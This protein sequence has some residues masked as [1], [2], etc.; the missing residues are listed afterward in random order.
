MITNTV[1]R[2]AAARGES[3]PDIPLGDRGGALQDIMDAHVSIAVTGLRGKTST[4]AMLAHILSVLGNDP[5]WLLGA[6][7]VGYGAG[8]RARRGAGAPLVLEA[9]PSTLATMTPDICVISGGRQGRPCPRIGRFAT[10]IAAHEEKARLEALPDGAGPGNLVTYGPGPGATWTM[11]SRPCGSG[12]RIVARGPDGEVLWADVPVPVH[13][14]NAMGALVAATALGIAPMDAARALE[15][16]QGVHRHLTIA[17][18]TRSVTVL[19]SVA[20]RPDSIGADLAAARELAG[21]NGRVRVLAVADGLLAHMIRISALL[22]DVD[23]VLT[24]EPVR[25]SPGDQGVG[26][27]R[28][29]AAAA[30]EEITERARPGDVIVILG[31]EPPVERLAGLVLD[32]LGDHPPI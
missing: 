4:A 30:V 18:A 24:L 22:Q 21:G 29:D 25:P 32:A 3:G 6:D 15:S 5:S 2:N 19:D 17:G 31:T 11:D 27:R 16:Y 14:D 12:H 26:A 1:A 20:R 28:S 7:L 13:A 10:V 8:S 23:Q 9:G